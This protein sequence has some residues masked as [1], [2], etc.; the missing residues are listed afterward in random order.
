MDQKLSWPM[1][2]RTVDFPAA[3]PPPSSSSTGRRGA[4]AAD[5]WGLPRLSSSNICCSVWNLRT[6]ARR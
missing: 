6:G 5:L 1:I 4:P 2:S 3:M